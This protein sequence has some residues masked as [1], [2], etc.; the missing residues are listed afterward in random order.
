MSDD[1]CTID[2]TNAP[3]LEA[4][5]TAGREGGLSDSQVERI[6]Y[7]VEVIDSLTRKIAKST[8]PMFIQ[9]ANWI[10]EEKKSEIKAIVWEDA[11]VQR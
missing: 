1:V 11:A 6:G 5:L 3:M 2:L 9:R 8:D 7:R 10:I 4:L